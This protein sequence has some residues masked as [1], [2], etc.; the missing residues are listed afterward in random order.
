M[1]ALDMKKLTDRIYY[2]P[3]Q[4][5]TDRPM[6]GYLR[7]NKYSLAI[8][9]GY[10]AGH[11]DGFYG[12]LE[13]AGLETPDFTVI[14]HWHYDHTFG[15]HHIHG[16]SIA[17]KKTNLFLREQQK[18]ALHGSYM[19]RLKEED[20]CFEREYH[21]ETELSIVQSDIQFQNEILLDLGGVTARIFHTESPH[22]EDTVCIY[23]P[24]ER[25]LFLGDSTSE[26]FYH[27]GY[28][29]KNKLRKLMGM[30]RDTD[31][32]YCILSHTEPLVKDELLNYLYSVLDE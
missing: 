13:K 11:V 8:D 6:L 5:E 12:L 14:T 17:H 22:S 30:I 23:C 21:N 26:D 2:F 32:A 4:P 24:E 25:V 1:S 18:H 31:C 9:A 16:V 20:P 10:S 29:D 27:N 19:D 28:M 7:G 3:H 15:M